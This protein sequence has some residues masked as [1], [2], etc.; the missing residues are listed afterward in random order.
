MTPT[1]LTQSL[2]N[3]GAE[4]HF[5]E[6]VSVIPDTID[7]VIITP[8]IPKTHKEWIYFQ[9]K[10]T[11]I[12][13]RSE[14]LGLICNSFPTVAVAGTHGKTT[15]T[16]MVTHFLKSIGHPTLAFIGGISKNLDSN[17]L[18]TDAFE[19]VV[20]EADEF[21][22]SFLTLY[23]KVGIITSVDAD[24]LDIYGK[25]AQLLESFQTFADQIDRDGTLIIAEKIAHKI[26]HPNKITYGEDN[27]ADFFI[28][29]NQMKPH[30]T[31]FSICK[32][33]KGSAPIC[34]Q[35]LNIESPGIHNLLNSLAAFLAVKEILRLRMVHENIAECNKIFDAFNS[36]KG[37]KRRFDFRMVRNDFVF[38]DD[39]AHHPE[40]IRAFL[41][42]IKT[43]YPNLK[44]TGVFQPHLYSRTRDFIHDFASA[45]AL[46]DEVILLDIYPARELPIEGITSSYLLDL[47]P[48]SN[49]K[50][51]QKAELVPYLLN[52]KPELLLTIGAGDIDKLVPEIEAA[53][54]QS[55][56]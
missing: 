37:V 12:L 33:E 11:P 28:Q 7:L 2:I 43:I 18:Y 51:L 48:I 52:H 41:Q 22:R 13:K 4:I 49:K 35:N 8:A 16:S 30:Q 36:W 46:L 45:L 44:A 50:V 19:T 14:V 38:I 5:N 42:A 54:K 1:D 26:N 29:V 9:E 24:H 25:K 39:Y 17:F 31:N 20:V 47:I 40:E 32:T 56:N 34:F 15:T 23:P 27:T 53:F 6:N 55:T 10:G 21:D 3:M